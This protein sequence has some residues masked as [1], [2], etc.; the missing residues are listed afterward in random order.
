MLNEDQQRQLNV[1]LKYNKYF[2]AVLSIG[3]KSK[4]IYLK[5]VPVYHKDGDHGL[6]IAAFCIRVG[7]DLE[8]VH[9]QQSKAG[10]PSIHDLELFYG[11]P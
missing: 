6:V 1:Y 11:K 8:G 7:R 5:Y 3:G 10:G 2:Y 9:D 4:S